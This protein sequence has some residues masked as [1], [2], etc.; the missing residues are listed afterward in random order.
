MAEKPVMYLD[1]DGVLWT[2]DDGGYSGALG[3]REFLEY[4]LANYEVRWCTTWAVS[5]G[6]DRSRQQTL[7]EWTG[8][9][10]EVW[11]Q[12][13]PS[14]GWR[15][16]KTGA[17]DWSEV[18]RGRRFVWI[19]DELLPEEREVLCE[20]GIEDW[21]IYTNVLEDPNAL[22]KTLA[23]LRERRAAPNTGTNLLNK[24]ET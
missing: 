9:P 10:V 3:L 24:E 21:F 4:A 11:E 16:F 2:V 12:V 23:K 15:D 14:L 22:L 17:I 1:V 20:R 6:M 5:G 8:E 19:E 13:R 7:E 18:E